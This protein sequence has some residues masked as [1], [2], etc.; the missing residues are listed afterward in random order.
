MVKKYR[1]ISINES[2]IYKEV[3]SYKD[4][5][6]QGAQRRPS[7]KCSIK[8]SAFGK[9]IS[10][11]GHSTNQP[12]YYWTTLQQSS[13]PHILTTLNGGL[14]KMFFPLSSTDRTHFALILRVLIPV[15]HFK[16]PLGRKKDSPK[17]VYHIHNL[18][19]LLKE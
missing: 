7:C 10:L 12:I 13:I 9:Q 4:F 6:Y 3:F 17:H 8:V 18:T 2:T 14:L 11:A 16:Y 1:T 19:A 5:L 15:S